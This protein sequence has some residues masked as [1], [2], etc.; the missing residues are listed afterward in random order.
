MGGQ[1]RCY[2]CH[3]NHTRWVGNGAGRCRDRRVEVELTYK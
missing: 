1:L 3:L 2:S